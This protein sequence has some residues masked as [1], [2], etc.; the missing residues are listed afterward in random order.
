MAAPADG[1]PP[2]RPAR[3]VAFTGHRVQPTGRRAPA[4]ASRAVPSPSEPLDARAP[5]AQTWAAFLSLSAIWGSSFLFIEVALEEGV[6][7]FTIVGMRAL[8]GACSWRAP[9]S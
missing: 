8:F 1:T 3:M 9:W 4:L 7:P 2:I 5:E 6:P